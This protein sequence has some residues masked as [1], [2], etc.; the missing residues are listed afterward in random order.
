LIG[1]RKI[2]FLTVHKSK[3]LEADYAILLQ[4]NNGTFGFPSQMSDDPVL[5]YVLS[6][7][8]AYP[9]G[10]ERR[11]FYVAITRAKEMTLVM[12]DERNPSVFVTEFLHPEKV[13]ENGS[14]HRN[15]DKRWTKKSEKFLLDLY[16][17]GHDI[18]YISQKM[19][20]SKTAIIYRLNKLKIKL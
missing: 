14:I 12:Y 7:G 6:E 2:E 16:R 20:R 17:E 13:S 10:E 3:G 8:D 19:G 5:K 1:G 18:N 4:C 9:N 11:L 15:A